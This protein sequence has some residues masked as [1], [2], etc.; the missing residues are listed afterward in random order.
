[1]T[2][3]AVRVA[4]EKYVAT[5]EAHACAVEALARALRDHSRARIALVHG[6]VAEGVQRLSAV[7]ALYAADAALDEAYTNAAGWAERA[8]A[9]EVMLRQQLCTLSEAQPSSPQ[10]PTRPAFG[11]RKPGDAC[12]CGGMLVLTRHTDVAYPGATLDCDRCPAG[13]DEEG[14]HYCPKCEVYRAGWLGGTDADPRPDCPKCGTLQPGWASFGSVSRRPTRQA[15]EAGGC[16]ERGALPGAATIDVVAMLM[17]EGWKYHDIMR[18]LENLDREVVLAEGAD[19]SAFA[20]RTWLM[21]D[22]V[23]VRVSRD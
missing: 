19:H 8:Q 2:T 3:A 23:A 21:G 1:M 4:V 9:D 15:V 7:Q 6:L 18:V 17:H 14:R 10:S 11:G 12:G 22:D 20:I 5:C 16:A 13:Y